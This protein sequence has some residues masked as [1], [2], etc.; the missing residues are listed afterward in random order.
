M[1]NEDDKSEQDRI[2]GNRWP[3]TIASLAAGVA[4]FSVWL[5]LL[6]SWLGFRVNIANMAPWRWLISLLSVLSF[7]IGLRCIWDFGWIGR[8][9]PSP[10]IP[11]K[12]LVVAGFYRYVRNPM[13]V[14]FFVGWIG[15][16][17]VFGRANT[18]AMVVTILVVLTVA[19]LVRFY[20]EPALLKKFGADYEEY[21][22]NVPGWMPRIRPWNKP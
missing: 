1:A 21:R 2:R 15:L 22:R 9:T 19:A 8:G 17:V 16:W 18:I 12:K 7:A 13:Y 11:P 4:F 20:E 5:W 14:G 6:P 3:M 10:I